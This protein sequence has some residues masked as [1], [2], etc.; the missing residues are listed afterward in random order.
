[1]K[2]TLTLIPTPIDEESPLEQVAWNLLNNSA[3]NR[4]ERSVF[5]VEDLRP[6]RRRWIRFGLPRDLVK[7][8]VLYNEHTRQEVTKTLLQELKLGKNVFLMS[9]GGMPAFCDPGRVLVDN[10]HQHKIQVTSTPFCNSVVLA[11]ALS[12]LNHE[13]FVF[14]GFLPREKQSRQVAINSIVGESQTVVIMDTPYRLKRLLEQMQ[15]A[16]STASIKREIFL[17]LDLNS[18]REQLFRGQIKNFLSRAKNFKREF[19]LVM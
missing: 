14:R 8:L 7:D 17:A 15:E 19:I 6:G 3:I 10:C 13:Q 4:R 2:G 18:D 5:V 9:D 12:G 11:L 1:M 16:M